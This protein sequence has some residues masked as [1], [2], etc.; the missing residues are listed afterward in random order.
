[1]GEGVK[2][3]Q[4]CNLEIGLRIDGLLI[5]EALVLAIGH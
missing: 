2:V 4:E 1:M 5:P 3:G